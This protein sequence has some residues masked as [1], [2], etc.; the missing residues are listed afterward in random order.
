MSREEVRDLFSS[1]VCL[2]LTSTYEGSP[3]VI[4]EAVACGLPV[5]SFDVGDVKKVLEY[6]ENCIV[7]NSES[8]I[9]LALVSL[10]R[11]PKRITPSRCFIE[12]YGEL[13]IAHQIKSFYN[14]HLKTHI[15]GK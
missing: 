8:E 10:I 4:K 15:Q 2:V 3:Q 12:H 1:S 6:E 11:S 5:L 14:F 7:T 13:G 9:T